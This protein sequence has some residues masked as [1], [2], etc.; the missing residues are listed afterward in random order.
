MSLRQIKHIGSV[1]RFRACGAEGDVTFKKFTLIFGENGRGKTTLCSILR[2]LQTNDPD[3]VIGRTTLGSAKEPNIVIQFEDNSTAL[4]KGGAWNKP[5][6]RLRIFDAQYVAENVYF[7]DEIGTD[8]RRN[9][10]RVMLGKDGVDLANAYDAVDDEITSKNNEIRD[11]RNVLVA[12]VP[13]AQ[14]DQFIALTKDEKI[15]EKITA[16][17]REVEGLKEIDTLR[18]RALLQ[19][20]D[21]PPVPGRLV[22]ILGK[23]LEGVS[24]D[25]EAKVKKHLAEHELQEDWLATGLKRADDDCPFCGQKLKGV[26]LIAAY[27]TF[28]NAEYDKLR[29]EQEQY[30]ALPGRHYSDDKIA[31]L[32]SRLETNA[33]GAEVWKRYVTFA[34]PELRNTIAPIVEAFRAEM[35]SLL[36]K[37]HAD[38]LA[39]VRITAA[40]RSEFEKLTALKNEIE[41]YNAAVEEANKQI[42]TF[43]RSAT[44]ARLASAQNELKWLQLTKKRHEKGVSDSCDKFTKLKGEKDGLDK[45]KVDAR[46]KLDTY[47][48]TVVDGYRK[49]I[50]AF[51]K[52]FTAGFHLDKMKV[53]YSGRVPN[54]TF[55]VVI[56]ETN[57]DMGTGDTPLS[58]PSFRNTLSSGD[59]STL[60]LA[61]FLAQIKADADKANS[62]VVF[63]DPFNSQDQF[64]R[65]CTMGEIR[66]CGRDVAQVVVMSHDARFLRDLWEH[67][68]PTDNR[69][70]LWLLAYG[71]RDTMIAEWSIETDTESEDAGNRR[72]L[73]SFYHD[74]KGSP[75]DVVQKLR[76]VVETHMKRMAPN[77]AKVK[78]LGNMLSKV[79][80]DDAPPHLLD[81][82]DDLDD[83][84]N[85]TRKYMHGEGKNPD[86]EPVSATELHGFVGKVLEF[87]GA[88]TE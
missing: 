13:A 50:N 55:C 19:A 48:N 36:D 45:K 10:C 70:A 74:N 67:D 8:Q 5:N 41:E 15:S 40:Y 31:L 43:K 56:N 26:D 34:E 79:R 80:G 60:A 76:P 83:I 30:R 7:G 27:R 47:S 21:V 11:V 44:P 84:N 37:K 1:G 39:P 68:L 73:L 46:K 87:A 23:T 49:S 12:H 62:I 78:G 66:R 33:S 6:D 32:N 75:R 4:F 85:Y 35:T 51:L 3:I 86:T 29:L 69:K 57:V 81:C 42:E 2:S 17:A 20:L 25:A 28:F 88:L 72:V 24:R 16:K 77:L 82:Y 38:L 65:T 53:E 63:D 71:H 22:E 18:N 52:K 59:K 61:F 64:R 9:L 14:L 58:E 54:S